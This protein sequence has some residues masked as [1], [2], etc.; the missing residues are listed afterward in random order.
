MNMS[1]TTRIGLALLICL[2]CLSLAN[3]DR[4][5]RSRRKNSK[6]PKAPVWKRNSKP[7]KGESSINALEGKSLTLVCPANGHPKPTISWSRDGR[8]VKSISN[9]KVKQQKFNLIFP[10]VRSRDAGNYTCLVANDLGSLNFTYVVDVTKVKMLKVIPPQNVTKSVGESATFICRV[11]NDPSAKIQWL[12]KK[13]SRDT[14]SM[15]GTTQDAVFLQTGAN[16]EVLHIQ[17][18]TYNDEGKYTCLA[19]NS[20]DMRY[21]NAWLKVV[22]ATDRKDFMK[23]MP[24]LIVS[25]WRAPYEHDR[26]ENGR[27]ANESHSQSK[28]AYPA[29]VSI[30]TI[31]IIVGSVSGGVLLIGLITIIVAVCC[32]KETSGTYKSTNV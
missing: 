17:N 20:H 27:H 26:R 29:L 2:L 31:Y 4:N 6:T 24:P 3:C 5:R 10:S 11:P 28:E 32:Q 16:P 12:F 21:E 1:I 19:G 14:N 22:S 9:L 15:R 23:T 7:R 13:V 18:V 8:G 25:T 30:W